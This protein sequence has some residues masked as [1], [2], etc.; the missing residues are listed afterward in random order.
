LMAFLEAPLL[1][2]LPTLICWGEG[3]AMC[4]S[5][6]SAV[7]L[8][9]ASATSYVPAPGAVKSGDVLVSAVTAKAPQMVFTGSPSGLDRGQAPETGAGR[10]LGHTAYSTRLNEGRK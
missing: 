9:I 2:G 5:L 4:S 3:H 6:L 1:H 10:V 8:T 7:L